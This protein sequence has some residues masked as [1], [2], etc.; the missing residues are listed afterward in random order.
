MDISEK[1]TQFIEN[2]FIRSELRL[3]QYIGKGDWKY[4][5]RP[6]VYK[7]RFIRDNFLKGNREPRIV[8]IPGIRGVGKTTV[9]AQTYFE[10]K[11][12]LGAK[13]D[14]RSI[15]YVSLEEVVSTFGCNLSDVLNAY[16]KV[17]NNSFEGLDHDIFLF[18][19]EIQYDHNWSVALK[20]LRDKTNRALVFCSGSSAVALNTDANLARRAH[21]ERLFPTSFTEYVMI[22]N[23]VF[24]IF[25][26]K[27][28]IRDAIFNS[29][30]AKEVYYKL[31]PMQNEISTYY[32]KF[33]IKKASNTYLR[34]GTLPFAAV[35][36]N[37]IEAF[38]M[39]AEILKRVIKDDIPTFK[40]FKTENIPLLNRLLFVLSDKCNL[41]LDKLANE[42]KTSI[43]QIEKMLEAFEQSEIL[44][45]FKPYGSKSAQSTNPS[46]YLF[47]SPAFRA[48]F[49]NIIA[50]PETYRTKLGYLLEDVVG[51]YLYRISKE[52]ARERMLLFYDSS[53]EGAD[54]IVN[55]LK[56]PGNIIFEVGMGDK[57]IKQVK[58]SMQNI[59][60][61]YGATI[62]SNSLSL[63]EGEN[64]VQ[65]P[66]RTFLLI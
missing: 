30:N 49:Y 47:M 42:V 61:L 33:D 23:N 17:I 41:S 52:R 5:Q 29:Q 59:P 31:L 58:N 39:I 35:L 20:V 19:D 63:V 8:I 62:S 12:H 43:P 36:K 34:V 40:N 22:E 11:E 37:E 27:D 50:K 4:P 54:F 14:P 60:S 64:I 10:L 51:M 2:Q 46:K 26:L 45:R 24:P 32:A 7:T 38:D 56:I 6:I 44:I 9:L 53:R 21:I 66:L 1:L 16:E 13:L 55:N 57:N 25:G 15:L 65:I 3:R 48:S 28:K 18:F